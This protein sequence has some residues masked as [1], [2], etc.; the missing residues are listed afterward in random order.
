MFK[1]LAVEKTQKLQ[2][3][4]STTDKQTPCY[5]QEGDVSQILLITQKLM[6]LEDL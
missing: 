1:D 6:S 5:S 3:E 2:P 4:K